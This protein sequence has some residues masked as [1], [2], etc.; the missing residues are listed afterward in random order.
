M[1]SH[2]CGVP[3]TALPLA[4]CITAKHDIPMVIR[5]REAKDYGT[6]K[7]IEGVFQDG[8]TCLIIEDIV[9]SGSSV[10]ETAQEINNVGMKVKG[11]CV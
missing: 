11:L 1:Y 7:M 5:R 8:D 4:T 6:K 2:V 9:T 3:Y 10:S